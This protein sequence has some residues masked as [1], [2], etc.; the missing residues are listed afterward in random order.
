[1]TDCLPEGVVTRHPSLVKF[2][3]LTLYTYRG[4]I[5]FWLTNGDRPIISRNSN[6]VIRSDSL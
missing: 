2:F 1:M 6:V 3:G 4:F 5:I